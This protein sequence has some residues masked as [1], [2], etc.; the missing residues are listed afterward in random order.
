MAI[1]LG[2][3]LSLLLRATLPRLANRSPSKYIA[4][5]GGPWLLR[6]PAPP[7]PAPGARAPRTPA[8]VALIQDTN[9]QVARG[10]VPGAA[11]PLLLPTSIAAMQANSTPAPPA[12]GGPVPPANPLEIRATHRILRPRL[13]GGQ[14][15]LSRSQHKTT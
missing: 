9:E 5:P 7:P 10:A 15:N 8:V 4:P 6:N 2:V 11:N 12:G 13:V 14:V 3:G 1:G